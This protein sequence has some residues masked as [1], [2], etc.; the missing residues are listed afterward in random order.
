MATNSGPKESAKDKVFE[1]LRE[2][3][4]TRVQYPRWVANT[5]PIRQKHGAW[6]MQMDYTILNKVSAKDIDGIK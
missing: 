3:I 6:Q 4:I 1:W 2:G 5:V